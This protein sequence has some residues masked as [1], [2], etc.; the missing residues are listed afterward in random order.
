MATN[1]PTSL[2]DL[3][4]TRGG[5]ND[6]LSTPNHADHHQLEDDTIEALQTKVGIDNS[7][8]SSSIDYKL[9]NASSSN[10][11]HKHTLVDGA[12]DVTATATELNYVDGVTSNIQTQLD[13]K[14]SRSTL[15]TK[16]D[17]Y[18]ATASAT[19]TRLGKGT[20]GQ[21]L[22]ADSVATEGLSW[23]DAIASADIQT[24]TST[25][26]NTWNKPSGAKKVLVQMWGAGASGAKNTDTAGGGG[27]GEYTEFMFNAS[28]L[29]SSETVT[30]GAG[31]AARSTAGSGNAG[32]NTTFGSWITAF[33][34]QGGTSN[35]TDTAS[36]GGHGGNKFGNLNTLW[37]V[38]ATSAGGGSGI[39]SAAGGGTDTSAN[40]YAGG[41]SYFG[42][43]GGGGE[44]DIGTSFGNGAGGTSVRGGNGGGGARNGN[45]TAGSAPGGG[46]GANTGTGDSGAGGNGRA[47]I[48]TFF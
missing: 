31:G 28:D 22:K 15:T 16:G 5:N 12:T 46:G 17:I 40:G 7:A 30:I 2:Q 47:I 35:N 14:Q 25:G 9:T 48:T 20:D 44:S 18:V 43:A 36:Q 3:D 34:G 38:G 19:V 4:P 42:G 11:G 8:D 1:F 32:G 24:F 27:G 37:G 13:S 45:A 41:D 23:G 21:F 29:G 10:P 39:Y 6:P 33:G 26:A